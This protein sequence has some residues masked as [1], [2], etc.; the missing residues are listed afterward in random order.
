MLE[1][2]NGGMTAD[3][4]RTHMSLWCLL[5]APLMAGND[6]RTMTE[7]TKSILMNADVVAIDQDREFKPVERL[8]QE[9]K[10]EVLVRP[11][12]GNAFAVGLFNRGDSPAQIGFRWEA[13]KFDTGLY[14]FRRLQAQDLWKHEAV[15]TTGDSF[16]A[17]VPRHGVVLLR[18]SIAGGRGF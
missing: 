12:S 15:P 5:A 1:V 17:T 7:E 10:S 3:E 9:G 13:L 14:G 8:S 18:V 11:L 4:Y 2:G 6:L 16:T